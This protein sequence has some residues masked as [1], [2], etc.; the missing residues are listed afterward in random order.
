MFDWY[1]RRGALASMLHAYGL[2]R[3]SGF[4]P[5]MTQSPLGYV[6][7]LGKGTELIRDGAEVGLRLVELPFNAVNAFVQ[8]AYHTFNGGWDKYW[9]D[10]GDFRF[11]HNVTHNTFVDAFS[12]S[13]A[14][15]LDAMHVNLDNVVVAGICFL[16]ASYLIGRRR[17]RALN[18]VD[19]V[20]DYS[21]LRKNLEERL[22][23]G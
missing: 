14:K 21:D 2:Y 12:A 23:H 16:G 15:T 8:G 10:L 20:I 17:A 3:A 4:F 5:E 18:P 19:K 11:L 13:G 7:L 6:P 9:K 22:T 1:R